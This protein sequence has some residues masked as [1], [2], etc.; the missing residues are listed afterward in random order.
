[1]CVCVCVCV[2]SCYSHV[3]LFVILWSVTHHAPLSMGFSRQ[4]YW[5]GFPC[6]RLGDLPDPG[7]EPE[8]LMSPTLAVRFLPLRPPEKPL[9]KFLLSTQ[10]VLVVKSLLAKAGD[11]RDAGL[12]PGSGRSP[13]EENGNPF[14]YSCLENLMDREAWW[15]RVCRV[16]KSWKL[17]TTEAT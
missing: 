7:I 9:N 17:E 5:N 8:S 6:P 15:A 14:R 13:G 16:A 10:V 11:F 1:M 3:Q 2:L 12:I 4:E